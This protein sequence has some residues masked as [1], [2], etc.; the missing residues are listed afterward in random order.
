MI[1]EKISFEQADVLQTLRCAS[2]GGDKLQQER[3]TRSYVVKSHEKNWDRGLG[4]E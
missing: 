3:G 4:D 1:L 2:K